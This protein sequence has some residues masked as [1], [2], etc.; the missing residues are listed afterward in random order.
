MVMLWG[1]VELVFKD[2]E[3]G[4]Y[5]W[6]AKAHFMTVEGELKLA[7]YHAFLVS[8]EGTSQGTRC[9]Y[10]RLNKGYRIPMPSAEM[11]EIS[12]SL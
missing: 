10:R 6:A 4:V 8:L 7:F 5:Y 2:G 9:I 11:V 12:S 3:R 1:D